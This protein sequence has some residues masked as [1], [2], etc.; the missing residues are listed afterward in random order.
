M[1][2]VTKTSLEYIKPICP[3]C[4]IETSEIIAEKLRRGNG[5]VAYCAACEHG[6][7]IHNQLIDAKEYYGELYRQEYSHNAEVAATHAREIYMVYKEYQQ[8]RLAYISRRLNSKTRLLEIGASAGQFLVH[9]KDKVSEVNAIELDKAC[10][11]FLGSEHGID[12]D[13]EFLENSRFADSVYDIVCAF[14][15]MEHVDFPVEFLKTLQGVTKKGGAIYVEVPNL[16]DPLLSVWDVSTY[17]QFFYHSAHLHYFTEASLIKV[18]MDAGFR[19]DQ[20]EISFS[21][22]YNILNHLHWVMNNGPQIDCHVGLSSIS[23]IGRDQEL[24]NWLN[25]EL[26]ILNSKYIEKLIKKKFTSNIMM[27]LELI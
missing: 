15:V 7:L 6:F 2:R 12:A 18:A 8:E 16:H 1:T 25:D 27:K 21:Q 3:L 9:I 23:L 13:S 11:A 14:Q 19:P 26:T 22:D 17:R 5:S 4:A 20:I 24:S 10:C